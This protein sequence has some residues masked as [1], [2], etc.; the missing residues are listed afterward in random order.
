MAPIL[1]LDLLNNVHH[2]QVLK[3]FTD[4]LAFVWLLVRDEAVKDGLD[5][6]GFEKRLHGVGYATKATKAFLK[7]LESFSQ[8]LGQE[9]SA[10]VIRENLQAIEKA[11]KELNRQMMERAISGQ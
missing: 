1:G 8:R 10:Q 9:G 4:Q 7:E 3:S 11:Q 6:D 5:E 2:L